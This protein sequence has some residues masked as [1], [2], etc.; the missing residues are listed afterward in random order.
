MAH[1][2]SVPWS[3]HNPK[4]GLDQRVHQAKIVPLQYL[5]SQVVNT[6]LFG[7]DP[8]GGQRALLRSLEELIARGSVAEVPTSQLKMRYG[9]SARCF[10]LS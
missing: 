9:R 4:N 5:S 7:S 8:L 2:V 3:F 10:Q 1:F 6:V